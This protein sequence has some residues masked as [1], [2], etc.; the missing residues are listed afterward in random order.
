MQN[1]CISFKVEW[2]DQFGSGYS[3][4]MEIHNEWRKFYNCVGMLLLKMHFDNGFSI[5]F[6]LYV[7]QDL[8]CWPACS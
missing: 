1:I 6:N 2:I 4:V 3:C 7:T 5:L 8:M